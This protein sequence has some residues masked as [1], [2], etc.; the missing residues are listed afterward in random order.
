MLPRW[1]PTGKEVWGVE[2]LEGGRGGAEDG[3]WSVKK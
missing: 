3:I 1:L 2:Q